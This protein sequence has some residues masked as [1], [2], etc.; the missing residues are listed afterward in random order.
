L[1][2]NAFIIRR[3]MRVGVF[4]SRHFPSSGLAA[5]WA[6]RRCLSFSYID[7]ARLDCSQSHWS[8]FQDGN[9]KLEAE[10]ASPRRSNLLF[11][12]RRAYASVVSV[13]TEAA[14]NCW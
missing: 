7:V 6:N 1:L 4:T 2:R 13:F 14:Q 11:N 3:M 10:E 12:I 8:F 5:V 9:V